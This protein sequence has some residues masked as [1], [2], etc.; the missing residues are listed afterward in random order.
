MKE[1][2]E[3]VYESGEPSGIYYDRHSGEPIPEGLFFKVVEVFVR[4]GDRLLLTQR[5]PD[6]WQGLKWEASGGGVIAGERD[7][8]SAVRELCEET[9][10][11]ASE[12]ELIYLGRYIHPPAMVESFLLCLDG[13]PELS[14]QPTEV[15]G[16][17]YVTKE[18]LSGIGDQLTKDTEIRIERYLDRIFG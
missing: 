9:G 3:L 13:E 17:K 12:E 10:I 5:H 15:V 14:L 7:S 2:W 18:A 6:K 8:E 4:A 16:A 11:S 1:I